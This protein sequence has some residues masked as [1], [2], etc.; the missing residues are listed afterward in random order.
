MA[1]ARR[2]CCVL[3]VLL[4]RTFIQHENRSNHISRRLILQRLLI[5]AKVDAACSAIHDRNG[6]NEQIIGVSRW[7]CVSSCIT[8]LVQK[9]SGNKCTLWKCVRACVRGF[10][11]FVRILAIYRLSNRN[12]KPFLLKKKHVNCINKHRKRSI[13]HT[14]HS[15]VKKPARASA[16][17]RTQPRHKH[18][19]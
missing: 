4:L 14:S 12:Q 3:C 15:P 9:W 8:V 2:A 6:L 10:L 1:N 5:F 13:T 18:E 17:K 16:S 11:A 7:K 19:R